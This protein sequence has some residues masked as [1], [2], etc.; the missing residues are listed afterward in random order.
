MRKKGDNLTD[1]ELLAMQILWQHGPMFV[2]EMLDY[3]PDP[4]PHVNT[5]ST[6]VRILED[7]GY[8]SHEAAGGAYRYFAIKAREQCR[9]KSFASLVS[10]FFDNSY[11]NAVSALVKD[12]KLSV[13]DLRDI[14]RMIEA[15]KEEE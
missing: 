1:K 11:K 12:E 8:V 9:Q 3:Y 13:E 6:V 10:G 14:I 2:R 5:V 15:S 7:K 4:K